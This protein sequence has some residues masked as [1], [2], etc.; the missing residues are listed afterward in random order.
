M[1]AGI[2]DLPGGDDVA[3]FL[4]TDR[5]CLPQEQRDSPAE[6]QLLVADEPGGVALGLYLAPA[7]LARLAQRD[8]RDDLAGDN[9]SDCWTALEGVSHFT[10]VAF[11]ARHDRPV[12]LHELELQ[13]EVDKYVCSLWLLAAQRP[14]SSPAGLHELLFRRSRVDEA[15]AGDRAPMY[16]RANG[17][18]ARYCARLAGQARTAARSLSPPALRELRRF[19]RLTNAGKQR[20]ISRHA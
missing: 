13:A 3:R 17:W 15:R 11:H 9:L 14:A 7:L 6:E 8:P 19:Y 5:A 18:A 4:L 20:W 12:S 10:Y 2:Y 1:L 16:R